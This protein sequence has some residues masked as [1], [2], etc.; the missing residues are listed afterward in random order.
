MKLG[1]RISPSVLW[2]T[3]V[4]CTFFE[5]RLSLYANSLCSPLPLSE[6]GPSESIS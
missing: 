3:F 4:Q 5:E 6:R 1:S 2:R